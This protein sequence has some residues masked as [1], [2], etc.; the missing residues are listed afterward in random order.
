MGKAKGE[1]AADADAAGAAAAGALSFEAAMDEIEAIV[2]EMEADRVPLDKLIASY[3]RGTRLVRLCQERLDQ[4]Q[5]RI[6][7]IQHRDTAA[8]GSAPALSP[9]QGEP[10]PTPAPDTPPAPGR[11]QPR[12]HP[13]GRKATQDHDDIRL[14]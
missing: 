1:A 5:A 10:D 12:P 6:D 8:A 4:A 13:K 2:A 3:E 11:A 14:L 7:I 9:F